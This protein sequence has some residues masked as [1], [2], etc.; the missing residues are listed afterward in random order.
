MLPPVLRP[1]LLVLALCTAPAAAAAAAPPEHDQALAALVDRWYD[2]LPTYEP[3][4]ATALGLH[5]RDG[6]LDDFSA[7]ALAARRKHLAAARA[8][9][10]AIDLAKLTPAHR[11]DAR[12]FRAVL[13]GQRFELDESQPFRHRA[14]LYPERAIEGLYQLIKHDQAPPGPRLTA[15][16]ARAS[17]IP[18]LLADGKRDLAE[19]P[20]VAVEVGLA[21][22]DGL[23][24][25]VR[26]AVPAAFPRAA[27]ALLA[28][29]R[30]AC[31]QAALA[32]AD[33]R[34]FLT[35]LL[36]R[37]TAPFALGERRF[38]ELLR[39]EELYDL[40]LDPLL[41]RGEAELARLE[42]ELAR[43]A[44]AIDPKRTP[45]ELLEA[46]PSH[47]PGATP[48]D[49]LAAT[50]GLMDELAHFI[51]AH[52]IMTLPDGAR[53]KVVET[54]PYLR[55]TTMA[56]LDP[57]GP[58]DQGGEALYTVTLP[59]PAW[60][61]RER[62][63]F[64]HVAFS[65]ETMA[66]RSVHEAFPGHFVHWLWQRRA[67]SKVRRAEFSNVSG[68]GWA[69]YCEQMMVDEGYGGGDPWLRLDQIRE[70]L[71]RAARMVAAIKLHARG[72][73][74]DQ[75]VKLFIERGHQPARSALMEARRGTSDP[76]YLSYTLGKLEILALREAYKKKLGAGY[77]LRKFHDAFAA[78]GPI[79]L[80]LV[81]EAL[82]GEP[83]GEERRP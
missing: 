80:P 3:V 6:A 41:A 40:P 10:D 26:G 78:E 12:T 1:G 35:R 19:V 57:P 34:L 68:E 73:T 83:P 13:D 37:A 2:E 54:P 61:E 45:A 25:F 58:F 23:V 43:T 15:A 70:A 67:S 4:R 63:E 30:A 51:D 69:H 18:R 5:A 38:R 48:R 79:P 74:L 36:P 81:R 39:A 64:E 27:P 42:G 76:L 46:L 52:A 71:L 24:A 82:L 20:R 56:S 29:L 33:Y 53:P 59:D 60:P 9:L 75:A 11:R 65:R 55:A 62:I 16:I 17:E 21:D 44:K 8:A 22:L 50:R 14:D 72:M 28:K 47:A 31:E 77:S 66:V 7:P 49:P 32:L